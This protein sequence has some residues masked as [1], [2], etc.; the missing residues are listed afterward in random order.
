MTETAKTQMIALAEIRKVRERCA[1]GYITE[2]HMD[3]LI[4]EIKR[5]ALA[6]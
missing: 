5:A 2:E 1:S 4:A 3:H 6:A